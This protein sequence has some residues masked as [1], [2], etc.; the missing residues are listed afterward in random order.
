MNKLCRD[1]KGPSYVLLVG[2]VEAGVQEDAARTVVP[3]LDGGVGRMKG[4]PSDNGY[5]CLDDGRE[6]SVA[7]RPPARAHGAGSRGKWCGK[8]W[9]TSA[10][11][12]R[13]NGGIG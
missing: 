2:A 9:P 6:P 5:G 12:S 4:Q 13:A 7:G 10:T 8:R 3:P 11:T 1:Y